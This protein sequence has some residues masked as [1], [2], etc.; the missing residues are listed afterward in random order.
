MGH[1]SSLFNGVGE[2]TLHARVTPS[3]EQRKYLQK[4]WSDLAE[5]LKPS[6]RERSGYEIS[7]WIQGSYKFGTLIKPVH[8]GEE[9]D[10]DLGIY[11]HWQLSDDGAEPTPEQLRDW[12]QTEC[13]DYSAE[14]YD[15]KDVIRPPK[16]RC[17]RLV[18]EQQF[19]I[20]VPVYHFD[21]ETDKVRLATFTKGWEPSDPEKLYNWF[22]DYVENPERDQLR[23]VIRYLKGWAAVT[24]APEA[25][26]R[27]SSVVI[28][29][30]AADAFLAE[31]V[32]AAN[33]QDDD[34]LLTVSRHMFER[35]SAEARVENP[36][37]A[38]EDL[39]R[40]PADDMPDLLRAL[41][42]LVNAGQ[43]ASEAVDMPGAALAW[44]DALSYLMPLPEADVEVVDERSGTA[45]MVLPEIRVTVTDASGRQLATY[46][47]EVPSVVKGC[48]LKF[49]I[50]NPAVVPHFATVEWTV[51]NHGTEA[52]KIG[53]LGHRDPRATGME[54]TENTAYLGR[55]FMDCVVKLEGSIWAVRRVP[56]RVRAAAPPRNPPRPQW[57]KVRSLLRRR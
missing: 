45:L 19:H 14:V 22:K 12:V 33:L 44:A 20:D 17:S 4:H 30:C 48:S 49:S 27:P 38:T 47:N 25:K 51:R 6:L 41:E 40:I 42:G 2:D 57:V 26:A 53:D 52:E 28:T 29:V 54:T 8:K 43:R 36:I 3:E 18:Y 23:R 15:I 34:A 39:N 13:E 9:Y 56:V 1:A 7:S 21:P 11:F 31:G 24:F 55:H 50:T 16:E 35:L 10:V 37:D 46:M 32:A 5:Y